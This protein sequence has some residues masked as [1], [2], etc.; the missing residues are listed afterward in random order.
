M[1]RAGVEVEEVEV[2]VLIRFVEEDRLGD[3]MAF[4]W[5]RRRRSIDGGGNR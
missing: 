5:A 1:G 3:A 2:E 4:A